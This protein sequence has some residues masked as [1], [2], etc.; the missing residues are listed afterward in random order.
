[1][2]TR[3]LF[4][5]FF[6]RLAIQKYGEKQLATSIFQHVPA[7]TLQYKMHAWCLQ[8]FFWTTYCSFRTLVVQNG[9]KGVKGINLYFFQL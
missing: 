8:R 9:S 7:S 4:R 2:E 1:M 6:A 5:F 3:K